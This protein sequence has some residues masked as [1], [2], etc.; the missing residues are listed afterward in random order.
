LSKRKLQERAFKGFFQSAK[1]ESILSQPDR[2]GP[3][4]V[5]RRENAKKGIADTED[6]TL[7]EWDIYACYF[8]WYHSDVKFRLIAWF[9][10]R[11]KT[12]LNCVYNFIPENQIPIVETRL[13]VDG[14]GF[15]EML[16]YFQEEVSTTKN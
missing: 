11:T 13:S 2:Y 1:V 16:K 4:P 5:K 14:K 6:D 7:A 9:H 15:A 8:S 3:T 12:M 10:Q